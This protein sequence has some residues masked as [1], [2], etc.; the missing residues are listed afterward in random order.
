MVAKRR[1]FISNRRGAG[2]A[3]DTGALDARAC[4]Q[5][6]IPRYPATIAHRGHRSALSCVST[7]GQ[8]RRF[9]GRRPCRIRRWKRSGK[10][11]TVRRSKR[12]SQNWRGHARLLRFGE[13][14]CLTLSKQ[15][16]GAPAPRDVIVGLKRGQRVSR[17]SRCRDQRLVTIIS[18]LSRLVWTSSP[19]HLPSRRKIHSS[20]SRGSGNT[21]RRSSSMNFPNRLFL[22]SIHTVSL[23]PGSS[24]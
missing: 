1:P 7:S 11:R 19:S 6:Q 20:S 15:L 24:M 18:V 2:D 12:S 21:E 23:P 3:Q 14:L 8:R 9:A 17:A 5:G 16:L 13:V 10:R 22:S 4:P